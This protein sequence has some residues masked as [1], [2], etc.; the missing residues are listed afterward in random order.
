MKRYIL[1]LD[2]VPDEK[3]IAAYEDWHRRVWPGVK[4]SIV[5]SGILHM[6]IYRFADRLCMVM[7]TTNEF[8][9]EKK[10]A[11]DAANTIVQEWEALMW[12][13]QRQ[14]PGSKPGEKW[15]LMNKIFEINS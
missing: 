14:I 15:V 7:E 12:K 6:A 10:A 8:T 2:L 9:L 4:R 3:M 11:S 13:Y 5:D 1:A